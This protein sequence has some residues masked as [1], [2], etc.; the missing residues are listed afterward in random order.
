MRFH[1]LGALVWGVSERRSP[2]LCMW[3]SWLAILLLPVSFTLMV[4]QAI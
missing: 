3:C 4:T 2:A 1:V